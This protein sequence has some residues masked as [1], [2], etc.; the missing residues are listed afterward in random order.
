MVSPEDINKQINKHLAVGNNSRV[1]NV[2]EADRVARRHLK[3]VVNP[4]RL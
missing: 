4:T 3:L 1:H 2:V